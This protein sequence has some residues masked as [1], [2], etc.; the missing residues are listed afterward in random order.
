M[1]YWSRAR[2]AC[3]STDST[4]AHAGSPPSRP[5]AS[6]PPRSPPLS[7]TY[8]RSLTAF[9]C[10]HRDST[11]LSLSA[12]SAAVTLIALTAFRRSVSIEASSVP[13]PL[14]RSRALLV[15]QYTP[16]YLPSHSAALWKAEF[17]R[18]HQN[19]HSFKFLRVFKTPS[20]CSRFIHLL[21][22]LG[23][24]QPRR[25]SPSPSSAEATPTSKSNIVQ[26]LTQI[27]VAPYRITW[28]S[29]T[30]YLSQTKI[31]RLATAHTTRF[32]YL[33]PRH[34]FTFSNSEKSAP[35]SIVE[36]MRTPDHQSRSLT[37]D[38]VERFLGSNDSKEQA[39]HEEL[40]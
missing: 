19:S 37:R 18:H 12:L 38:G 28:S 39:K 22:A 40:K 4:K 7:L 8:R 29:P 17:F 32:E 23:C 24:L 36:P 5:P 1:E 33:V 16:D 27:S 13:L 21:L 14:T 30:S 20:R 26:A 35:D 9:A 2:E 25:L 31:R 15:L 11:M 6:P 10:G 3:A 34:F